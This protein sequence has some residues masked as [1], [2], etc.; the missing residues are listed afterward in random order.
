MSSGAL[1]LCCFTPL[2]LGSWWG[3]PCA[4]ALAVVIALRAVDEEKYLAANLLGYE[5]HSHRVR[6]RLVPFLW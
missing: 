3:L 4:F 2:A 5:A 6:Y 1:A